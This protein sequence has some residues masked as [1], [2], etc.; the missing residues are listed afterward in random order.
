[1]AAVVS[2]GKCCA[3]E[4]ESVMGMRGVIKRGF[5]AW[6]ISTFYKFGYPTK[7]IA[8]TCACSA[9]V[10]HRIAGRAGIKLRGS[11]TIA[12]HM[13]A[14]IREGGK[15]AAAALARRRALDRLWKNRPDLLDAGRRP[16]VMNPNA[17]GAKAPRQRKPKRLVPAPKLQPSDTPDQ[18]ESVRRLPV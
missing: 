15:K 2:T 4:N 6:E 10:V 13:R 11:A 3:I 18:T 1:M 12:Q 14:E 17:S 5:S 16:K 7:V 8:A 9:S